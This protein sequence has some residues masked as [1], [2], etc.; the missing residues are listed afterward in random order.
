MNYTYSLYKKNKPS[1]VYYYEDELRRLTTV[2]L[3]DI[4][5]REK[6]P[7][8]VAYKLNR[9]YLIQLILKYRGIGIINY[10]SS[11]D[12]N[13]YKNLFEKFEK[14]LKFT[15]TQNDYKIPASIHLYLDADITIN[16]NY[17]VSGENLYEGNLFLLDDENKLVGLLHLKRNKDNY[18]IT[19]NSM[20]L[21]KN[22][23]E[24][25][26]KSYSIGF[27]DN[28]T[29]N[30]FYKDYYGIENLK[31][32]K[33]YCH[34]K[35][36]NELIIKKTEQSNETLVI[37]FGTS[38]TCAGVYIDNV[39]NK[40]YKERKNGNLHFINFDTLEN[41]KK[42]SKTLPTVISVKNCKEE[43]NINYRFGY[44]AVKNAVQNS[45]S[46]KES[47]FYEIKRWVNQYETIEEIYDE[48]GN[49]AYISRKQL[50]Y[51]YLKYVIQT[52]EQQNKCKYKNIHI[53]SPVKQ[54]QQYLEL[55]REILEPEYTVITDEAL[56]EGVAVLYNS[57]SNRIDKGAF[58]NGEDYKALI[59]DCGGGTTDLTS[60]KYYIEDNSITY[61]L[62][63]T[64]LY[65]NGDINFGGNN[66]TF[67]IMQYLKIAFT[68]YYRDKKIISV[69]DMIEAD[70]SDIYNLVDTEGRESIY[71]KLEHYYEKCE[72]YIPTKYALKKG[73]ETEEYY[74]IRSNFYF[75]WNLAE[76]IKI[77]FY[78]KNGVMLTDFNKYGLKTEYNSNKIISEES[79]K[80]NISR[81]NNKLELE[82]ELPQIV[83][84]KREA[85][86]LLKADI[87][88]IIKK[89]LDPLYFD[90]SLSEYNYIKLTGQ[91]CQIDLFREALKEY[92]PG[93]I[94]ETGGQKQIEYKLIC[95]EGAL[96]YE[97][98]KKIG[99]IAPYLSNETAITPYQLTAFN[100][101][102]KEVILITSFEKITKNYGFISM[103]ID[104][105]YIDFILKNDEEEQ[106]YVYRFIITNLNDITYED[107]SR[108]YQNK[109][110]QDDIDSIIENELKIFIF[111]YEDRWGFYAVPIGRRN[112][113]L[114]SGNK[115]YFPFE[116]EDWNINFYD[117]KK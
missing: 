28:K 112:G 93:K 49:I 17:I 48:N 96:K 29:S 19:C 87:Y 117:G 105:E 18:Y 110:L 99:K 100:Y 76:K 1:K 111:S 37:D 23:K 62:Y 88:N 24:A 109:I 21:N 84:T 46:R 83:I 50:I 22:L 71:K 52:A 72:N 53:T 102:N 104:T 114:V 51:Q 106:L 75:L 45:F 65:A 35:K 58:E 36:I 77:N 33:L 11:F 44:D 39:N 16:D 60:C 91:T 108:E 31:P 41:Q 12:K 13:G 56:D 10:I 74:K 26:Y 6:I 14:Y 40:L 4:C 69:S 81:N 89:F 101:S 79:W 32:I 103:N 94:I 90:E 63:L 61:Q 73:Y 116:N 34:V 27:L 107:T 57:I 68:Y 113:S 43:K 66:L 5:S 38:S 54:K 78:S 86:L 80:I 15:D 8:G 85:D 70:S 42:L 9:D 82:T 59:I 67:R 115:K 55:Y 64:T 47:V 20:F 92:I 98:A 2:Q 7:I 97:N 3:R 25:V 30:A 95:A